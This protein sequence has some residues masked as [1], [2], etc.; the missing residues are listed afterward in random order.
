MGFEQD[1]NQSIRVL[2]VATY[3]PHKDS[4]KALSGFR[5]C[6]D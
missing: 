2:A 3:A 1:G 4:S 6:R 5:G